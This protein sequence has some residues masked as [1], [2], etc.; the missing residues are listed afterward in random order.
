MAYTKP[1]DIIRVSLSTGVELMWE[2]EAVYLGGLNEESVVELKPI[3]DK[4]NSYGRTLV[5]SQLLDCAISSGGARL[6]EF[7]RQEKQGGS[8]C[9]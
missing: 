1:H 8:N 3:G 2:V 9:Y 5:P 6:Y 7:A 4:P